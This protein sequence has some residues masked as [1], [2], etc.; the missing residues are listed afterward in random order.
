MSDRPSP[1]R[2]PR[3]SKKP[4]LTWADR[5]FQLFFHLMAAIASLLAWIG[6]R[7]RDR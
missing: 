6:N 2:S 7:K 1:R 5:L 3:A 4:R